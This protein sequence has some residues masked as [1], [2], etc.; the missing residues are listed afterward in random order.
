MTEGNGL[1]EKHHFKSL[2]EDGPTHSEDGV[3]LTLIRWMLSMTLAERLETLQQHI[4]SVL[5]LL[6]EESHA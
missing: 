6:G 1:P 4:R 3:A 5:R 2:S